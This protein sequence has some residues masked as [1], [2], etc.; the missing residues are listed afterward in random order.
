MDAPTASTRTTTLRRCGAV[1]LVLLGFGSAAPCAHAL[2]AAELYAR[3]VPSVWVVRTFDKDGLPLSQGSAVVVGAQSLVTN[4]HVLRKAKRVEV[5][6][7]KTTW[8]ASLEFWD[9]AHDI[10][11]VKAPGIS[12]PPVP[13]G[14]ANTLVVGQPV[15]A[16]GSPAGM[17][18]TLSA[19]IV[20]ALRHDDARGLI[21][22]Q[23]SAA[24]SHGSS[25]GGLFDE[26]GQLIGITAAFIG[27]DAQNLN[28][29][30]PVEMVRE[31]PQRHAAAQQA[32]LN[33]ALT[34]PSGTAGG[35][36]A[37]P[38][39]APKSVSAVGP[40]PSGLTATALSGQWSG[41]Y[42]CGVYLG[43]GKV[44][45]VTPWNASAFMTVTSEGTA[46]IVRGNS[47][48]SETVTGEVQFDQPVALKGRGADRAKPKGFWNT[49][50][51]GQF[52][53]AGKDLRFDGRAR[54]LTAAGELTRD[55]VVTFNKNP[56]AY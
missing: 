32:K 19:G 12:A 10:C 52:V 2:S 38:P 53:G 30:V 33:A 4:C 15:Y 39:A 49:E 27:G 35:A 46:T 47:V 48:Y 44:Q 25:G 17:E 22:I 31:L 29:A 40:A 45:R 41:E 50:V 23:T 24:I 7:E 13:L 1:L 11:Q 56:S 9:T 26:Q 16:L 54:I 28:L 51:T 8:P 6:H 34:P 21:A 55:C 18:L 37:P 14:D 20:S 5:T 42:R 36:V 43:S 3:L